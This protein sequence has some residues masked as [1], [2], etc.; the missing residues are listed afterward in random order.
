MATTT[1][2]ADVRDGLWA[3]LAAFKATF[4]AL[5]TGDVYKTRPGSLIPVA[6]YIGTLNEPTITEPSGQVRMREMRPTVVIVRNQVDRDG[7]AEQNDEIVDDWVDYVNDNPH[8]AGGLIAVVSTQDVELQF[9]ETVY[10]A[11]VVYHKAQ[12]Q[13]GRA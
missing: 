11:T 6:M 12:I 1:F 7:G 5:V 2:R 10:S 4:P 3:Y 13:E 9:G 8:I